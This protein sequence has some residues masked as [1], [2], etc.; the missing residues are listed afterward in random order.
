MTAFAAAIAPVT[1][2]YVDAVGGQ[3]AQAAM[4]AK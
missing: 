2:A 4:Q 3:A 1:G